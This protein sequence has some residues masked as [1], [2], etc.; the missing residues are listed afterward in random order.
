MRDSVRLLSAL[1]A[2]TRWRISV[3]EFVLRWTGAWLSGSEET[4]APPLAIAFSC[5]AWD[6]LWL[7]RRLVVDFHTF[8]EYVYEARFH[9]RSRECEGMSRTVR[10]AKC[11]IRPSELVAEFKGTKSRWEKSGAV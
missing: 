7:F 1:T 4:H 11:N 8:C 5:I 10:R 3:K 9:D 6:T 2:T